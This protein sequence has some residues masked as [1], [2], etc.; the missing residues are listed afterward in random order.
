MRPRQQ[1]SKG[2]ISRGAGVSSSDKSVLTPEDFTYLGL[3]RVP[4]DDFVNPPYIRFGFG[5]G[6][7]LTCRRVNGELHLFLGQGQTGFPQAMVT[8]MVYATPHPTLASSPRLAV[9]KNWGNIYETRREVSD[10]NGYLTFGLH[11][12]EEK[13]H[14]LWSFGPGYSANHDR[15]IGVTTLNGTSSFTSYGPFRTTAHCRQTNGYMF[16]IPAEYQNNFGGRNIMI[17]GIAQ[18]INTVNTWGISLNAF[19]STNLVG[20]SAD[21]LVNTNDRSISTLEIMRSPIDN[22]MLRD[23]TAQECKRGD[24]SN[25]YSCE[26]GP[27]NVL[28]ALPEPTSLDGF[29]GANWIENTTKRGIVFI[30]NLV[31]RVN[32]AAFRAEH[33]NGSDLPHFWYS[34]EGIDCCHGHTSRFPGTGPHTSS[35]VPQMW[36]YDPE[37]ALQAA[38]GTITATQAVNSPS[39]KHK[40][41]YEMHPNFPFHWDGYYIGGGCYDPVERLFFVAHA[42]YDTESQFEDLPVIHVFQVAD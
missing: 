18:S 37:I 39:T 2:R 19:D 36:I 3:M 9:Y 20:A 13:Q 17:G 26:L 27:S 12:S 7:N 1:I 15:S 33:Y 41:L 32:D 22:K 31:D 25:N 16:N 5:L 6:T 8:E 10:V 4:T 29:E 34:F 30:C 24:G 38:A 28:P 11:W 14:L 23:A 42:G 21:S 40:H 35:A